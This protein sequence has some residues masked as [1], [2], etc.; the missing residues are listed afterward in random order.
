[1]E[2]YLDDEFFKII[3]SWDD[4]IAGSNCYIIHDEAELEEL[5]KKNEA[6]YES[7]KMANVTNL[8]LYPLRANDET[9]GYIWATNFDAS[10]TLNIKQILDMV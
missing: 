6:W 9:I 3:E 5:K 8:V 7:L 1:M 2:D 4:L 10:N